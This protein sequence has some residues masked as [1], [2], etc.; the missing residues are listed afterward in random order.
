MGRFRN[1]NQKEK[2]LCWCSYT[3][4]CRFLNH[5]KHMAWSSIHHWTACIANDRFLV[6][7]LVRV[8]NVNPGM[9]GFTVPIEVAF[10]ETD[11]K[12]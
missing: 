10:P 1:V 2:K 9:L 6:S 7:R 5:I 11:I 4:V 8:K 12:S 3:Q